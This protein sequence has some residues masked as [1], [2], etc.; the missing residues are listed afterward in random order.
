MMVAL[1]YIQAHIHNTCT[2]NNHGRQTAPCDVLKCE[3]SVSVTP[4]LFP[5]VLFHVSKDKSVL[6]HLIAK[7]KKKQAWDKLSDIE[8][9]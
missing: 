5:K 1:T 7:K 9:Q 4:H 8:M 2:K 6:D 3:P